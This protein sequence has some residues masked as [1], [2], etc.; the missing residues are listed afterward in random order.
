MSARI[1]TL[2]LALC[3]ITG[4]LLAS[5]ASYAETV[6]N[7]EEVSALI[8]GKTVNA[9]HLVKGHDFKVYFSPDGETAYRTTKKGVKETTYVIQED[10]RHCIFLKGRDRCAKIIN[11]GDGTYSRLNKSGEKKV[12]WKSFDQGNTIPK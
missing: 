8:V 7:A 6:L 1:T 12:L 2:R 5:T 11:N 10:G 3:V 9:H 4:S